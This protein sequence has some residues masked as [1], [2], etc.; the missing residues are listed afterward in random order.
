MERLT[1]NKSIADMSMFELSHNCCYVDGEG[2]A[3]YR[4]YE[5]EMDARDFARNLMITLTKDELPVD[6]EEFD[7]EILD[8]LTIDPFSDVRGLIAL[9]YR[10]MWAMADLREKLKRDEDAEEQGEILRLPISEDTPVYSIEYCCGNNKSNRMGM[11]FRGSC[12]N[13]GNKAY[14]IRESVAK[15]CSICEINKSV[16]LTSE[17]AEAKLKEMEENHG[18]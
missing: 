2:N 13:C 12:E 17:E 18:E 16:F 11:C 9:F 6:D 8:N 7:E 14:Y 15:H 10:N 4:D 5:M 1:V 3:R